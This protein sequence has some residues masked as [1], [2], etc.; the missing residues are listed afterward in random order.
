M[1]IQ[2]TLTEQQM[3][4]MRLK[5][6]LHF[7]KA[8]IFFLKKCKKKK[9]YPNF[10][11]V[12]CGVRNSRTDK[13]I[14]ISK[15]SWLNYELKY[16]YSKLSNTEL[17]TYN[18]HLW[19]AKEMEYT[20]LIVFLDECNEKTMKSTMRKRKKLNK[21]FAHIQNKSSIQKPKIPR[22]A[23]EKEKERFVR[24]L[25]SETFSKEEMDLL[26][27]GLNFTP[28][29]DKLP[30]E[31]LI[32]DIETGIKF[33]SDVTKTSIRKAAR[34]IISKAKRLKTRRATAEPVLKKLR[35][36]QCVYMKSDKGRDLVI[37][38]R[39]DYEDKMLDLIASS[40]FEKLR[41]SPLNK[42]EIETTKIL[43]RVE[44]VFGPSTKWKLKVSNAMVPKLYGLPKT[45]KTPLKMRPIISNNNAPTEKIA[46]WLVADFSKYKQPESKSVLNSFDFIEKTKNIVVEDD[47]V[48]VSFDVVA[49]FPSIP[50]SETLI[51]LKEWL[52]ESERDEEKRNVYFD[53]AK[54]CMDF[55]CC[56]FL[57]TFYKIAKG[58]A[59]GNA[60]SPFLANVFMSSLERKIEEE[61]M[62]PRV[63]HRYVDDVFA[64]IKED[65]IDVTLN[66]L[67]SKCQTV[68]FT[69]ERERDGKL[70]FLDLLISRKTDK[71]LDFA[72]Y[73]KPTNIPRYIPKESFCPIQYKQAAFNSMVFRMCKL[74][75]SVHN[76]MEELKYIKYAAQLNGYDDNMITHLVEK[77]SSLVRRRNLT[78]L[79]RQRTEEK[80]IMKI[81][82]APSVTNKLKKVFKQHGIELVFTSTNKL[83]S[84]LGSL[85]DATEEKKKS[86]IYGIG[87]SVCDEKYIGQ[88]KRNIET[89]FGEHEANIRLNRPEKSAVALHVNE[90]D[91]E[92][93][94]D[95]LKLVKQVNSERELDAWES[96]LM[97]KNR[98]IL[99]NTKEA[100]IHSPLFT[101]L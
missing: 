55:N 38:D 87:C 37:M 80:G 42:M 70:P 6:K 78:T 74:P 56:Q 89:R 20:E 46:K 67:N 35:E 39:S 51:L 95:N 50:I 3:S 52:Q 8:D 88:T 7:L 4:F 12:K 54:L 18:T 71:Q 91:H 26:Q 58:T 101:L 23:M 90:T 75:L 25:S 29:P 61:G 92:I 1:A 99:M 93:S 97:Y 40:S 27:K 48:L 2:P 33:M 72:V 5:K 24:N 84:K 69:L 64:V 19:L 57:N 76:Y 86:G 11:K 85:K 63:W 41:K 65:N 47:E 81:H 73:R 62:L 36:R 14:N 82:F 66:H 60:L 15:R 9:L 59:M 32:A 17:D 10:I 13:V 79:E 98:N 30:V 94:I 22:D 45:H 68:K 31:D 16:T 34:P 28:K 49:L 100:P 44:K 21:K 96:I 53:A 43:K 83:K 77:Q